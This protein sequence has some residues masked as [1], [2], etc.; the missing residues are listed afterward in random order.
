MEICLFG[1]VPAVSAGLS[2]RRR[3]VAYPGAIAHVAVSAAIRGNKKAL[4][5]HA[6]LAAPGRRIGGAPLKPALGLLGAPAADVLLVGSVGA[7]GT[8]I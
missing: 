6:A 4:Y 5:I 2:R 3:L 1:G 8:A 7:H